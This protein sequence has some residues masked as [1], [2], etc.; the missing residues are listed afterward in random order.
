MQIPTGVCILSALNNEFFSAG[1]TNSI[2]IAF[3]TLGF[4]FVTLVSYFLFFP[5]LMY[6][7]ERSLFWLTC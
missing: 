6:L 1:F 3:D 7:L 2:S 5:S 4:G